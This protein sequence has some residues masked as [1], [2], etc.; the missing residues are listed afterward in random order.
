MHTY[1]LSFSRFFCSLPAKSAPIETVN[2]E[3]SREQ[4]ALRILSSRETRFRRLVYIYD[5]IS[6]VQACVRESYKERDSIAKVALDEENEHNE[7]TQASS[8][9]H[10]GLLLKMGSNVTIRIAFLKVS[11]LNNVPKNREGI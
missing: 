9:R 2:W 3:Q 4:L 10:D 6:K 8:T 7:D 11:F 1:T 5:V